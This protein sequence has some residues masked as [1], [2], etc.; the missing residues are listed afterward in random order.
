MYLLTLYTWKEYL[1]NKNVLIILYYTE[2]NI[3]E[4][5]QGVPKKWGFVLRVVLRGLGASNQKMSENRP[6]LK[7]NFVYWEAFSAQ[8]GKVG[9]MNND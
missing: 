7:F 3:I 9:D 2:K 5:L 4:K 8:F 1:E 6:P